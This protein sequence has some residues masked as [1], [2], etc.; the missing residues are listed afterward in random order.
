MNFKKRVNGSWVD[1]PHYIHN[2]STD[3]ITTLPADIYPNAATATVGLK[4]QMEQSGTPTPTNP[5]QPQECGEITANMLSVYK[6]NYSIN[7]EG[8]ERPNGVAMIYKANVVVSGSTFTLTFGGLSIG[9]TV[10]IHAY[11]GDTW[12]GQIAAIVITQV[13]FAFTAASGVDNIRISIRKTATDVAMTDGQYKIPIS[14]GDTTTNIY[15]GEVETTRRVKKLVLDGTENWVLEYTDNFLLNTA[16]DNAQPLQLVVCTHQ[17]SISTGYESDTN[18]ENV[19]ISQTKKLN[20]R[21]RTIPHNLSDLKSYLAQ[22]YA[23]GTPVTVWYVLATEETGIVNEPLMKIGEYADEVS[24][25]SIPVTAGTNAVDVL[26]T[27]KP[28]EAT[29]NYKGWHPVS[30]VHEREN[31]AWT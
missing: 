28:S 22:Q 21:T 12:K 15:L 27:L 14:S 6:K 3:I 2:T 11:T 1:T 17:Q 20:F 13:P 16:I 29:V 7:E 26:T 4:G 5:I 9:D 8:V 10:R 30:A 24:G 31:G 18:F 23:A 25:I 19:R